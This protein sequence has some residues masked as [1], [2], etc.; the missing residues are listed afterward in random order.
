MISPVQITMITILDTA[1][2]TKCKMA[3]GPHGCSSLLPALLINSHYLPLSAFLPLAIDRVPF[4]CSGMN[5]S[6]TALKSNCKVHMCMC[7]NLNEKIN[8]L[9]DRETFYIII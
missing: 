4:K 9:V 2:G 1:S 6:V 7:M 5:C 8:I 3:E